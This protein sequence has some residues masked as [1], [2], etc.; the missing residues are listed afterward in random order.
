[1]KKYFVFSDVHGYYDELMKALEDKGFDIN[2]P[3]H[4]IISGGDI[5][6][7]GE[8]SKE[9]LE[10]ITKMLKENRAL[11]VLGNHA[12]MYHEIFIRKFFK[13]HDR[14]NGADKTFE[15]LSTLELGPNENASMEMIVEN[16]QANEDFMSY[17][18]SCV[19]YIELGDKIFVHG[20]IPFKKEYKSD[21]WGSKFTPRYDPD[22]RNADYYSWYSARWSNGMWCWN[23]GVREP[24]KTIYCGHWHCSWGNSNL[25]NDGKEF[26]DKYETMY[27]DPVT[28]KQEPHVNYD[29][30]KDDGIVCLDACTVISHKVNV[31]VFEGE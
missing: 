5:F 27:I 1:M 4:M 3:S 25:H 22:W 8:Q 19:N 9:C 20:W 17:L 14:H 10:F 28:G 11:C 16:V 15:Q 30:F 6:D 24:N 21:Y 18:R 13:N 26:L 23:E 31:E 12:E 2:D 7:R 29:T